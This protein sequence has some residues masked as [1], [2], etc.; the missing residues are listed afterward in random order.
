MQLPHV[1]TYVQQI[2]SLV[3]HLPLSLCVKLPSNPALRYPSKRNENI[4]HKNFY[5]N[6]HSSIIH[7]SQKVKIPQLVNGRTNCALYIQWNAICPQKGMK[8]S[9]I[10]QPKNLLNKEKPVIKGHIL[11]DSIYVKH[12][13][14]TNPQRQKVDQ[15]LPG[16]GEGGGMASDC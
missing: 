10:L 2:V 3:H 5:T 9:Y 14:E 6:I 8:F 4:H 12:P 16:A 13:E 7:N 1:H 11:Y 15:W